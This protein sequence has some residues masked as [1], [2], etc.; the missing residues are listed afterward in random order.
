LTSFQTLRLKNRLRIDSFS[1]FWSR[2]CKT[3]NKAVLTAKLRNGNPHFK[4]HSH[5]VQILVSPQYSLQPAIVGNTKCLTM[6]LK[7]RLKKFY[8]KHGK[9]ALVIF[10]V[11]FVTKWT[12]TIV[13]GAKLVAAIKGWLN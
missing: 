3:A 4:K 12:L 9:K 5:P 7:Y 6:N 13:F 1:D 8:V 10:L 2:F 11:Y